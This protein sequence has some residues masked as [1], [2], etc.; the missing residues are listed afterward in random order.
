MSAKHKEA[1]Q[2]RAHKYPEGYFSTMASKRMSSLS[3]E[4]RLKIGERLAKARAVKKS[5]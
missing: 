3:R 4:E 1:A 5:V 2:K